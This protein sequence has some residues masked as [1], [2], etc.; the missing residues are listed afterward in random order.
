MVCCG[1]SSSVLRSNQSKS[2]KNRD[3]T[4]FA[5]IS[6]HD[7]RNNVKIQKLAWCDHKEPRVYDNEADAHTITVYGGRHERP[8]GRA[9]RE[10]DDAI[11][12]IQMADVVEPPKG[13]I[14]VTTEIFLSSSKRLDYNDRLY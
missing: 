9:E 10:D 7:D 4:T 11:E 3:P 6:E 5:K 14:K 12:S 2:S 13:V 1:A 8:H